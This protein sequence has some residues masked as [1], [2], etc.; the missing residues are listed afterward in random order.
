MM[1]EECAFECAIGEIWD[2]GL[3]ATNPPQRRKEV[4]ENG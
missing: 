3:F 4:K 2:K 1:N